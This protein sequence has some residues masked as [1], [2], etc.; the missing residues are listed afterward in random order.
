MSSNFVPFAAPWFA[1]ALLAWY[2]RHRRDLPWRHT[3]DPYAIWLS[4][5]I[6]QQTRVKQG[7]PYYLD[8]ITTYPTVHDL[9]AAPQDEVLRHW[10]GLGYYSRARNM[11]HTAQQVV[12][13]HGGQFPGSYAELLKLR[14][15]G[16]YTAAAIASFAY[17]E[18]VAVLDGNVYRV[19]ARVFGITADIAAPASRKIFQQLADTLIPAEHP[20]EFNQAIMEFGAI[21]CT[22]VKP[23]C[24]FCP[25]QSQCYAF[26]HG[27]VQELPVKSKAKAGR[28]RY[29]HYLVLRYGDTL[30]MRKRG[31][32]DIWEGLYDFALLETDAPELP[33]QEVVAAVEA[34]GGQVA[35][36]LAEEP[37]RSLRHVLSHQK[38]EAKFHPVWLAAPL[39]DAALQKVGLTPYQLS[40]IEELPKSMLVTNYIS[41]IAI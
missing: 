28:T 12:Q 25:L 10:Q 3:R 5:V 8:F 39:P 26:Q 15:V 37:V 19:L 17:D 22:P 35:A 16:Q 36:T 11:H 2:P 24:L 30:Y 20:A 31:P 4:E 41:S 6:L 13:E 34:L 23:D 21:Q 9:A 1:P 14:G 27:M 18:Q 38:V 29:F 7:L 33:A 32:K 40:Q